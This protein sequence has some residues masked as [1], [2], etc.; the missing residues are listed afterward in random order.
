MQRVVA[1]QIARRLGRADG[2]QQ[3]CW[4][5][6]LERRRII[7]DRMMISQVSLRKGCAVP[8]HAHENEQFACIVS[9]RLRFQVGEAGAANPWT[10]S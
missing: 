1:P 7:G 10:A 2:L 6:L 3:Q 5:A 8:M 4:M 9:G